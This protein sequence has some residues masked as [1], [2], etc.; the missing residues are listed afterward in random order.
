MTECLLRRQALSEVIKASAL[1]CNRRT[2]TGRSE[3]QDMGT[4]ANIAGSVHNFQA[5]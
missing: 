2:T 4:V 3:R 5:R 1:V